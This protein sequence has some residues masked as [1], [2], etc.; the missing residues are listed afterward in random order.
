[1]RL[2]VGAIDGRPFVNTASVGAYAEL[3]DARERLE[4]RIGRWPAVLLATARVL[5]RAAPLEVE[6]D[7][8]RHRIWLLFAGNGAY[9][10]EGLVP[11]IRPR[12]DSG[13]LDLRLVDGGHP[14]ARTRLVLALLTGT[15][16]RCRPYRAWRGSSV[17]VATPQDP[18]PR[19]ARDGETF[20][21]SPS[22][23]I[24]LR[25]RALVVYAGRGSE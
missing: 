21:G 17:A 15:L 8:E 22:F 7:G 10:P 24:E 5:R 14:F 18:M 3:V 2:D 11:A 20:S 12:L 9:E 16:A 13:T 4:G 23:A 25:P 1:V 19:L 6:L